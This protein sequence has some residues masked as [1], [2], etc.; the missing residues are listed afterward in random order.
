MVQ[1]IE[2]KVQLGCGTLILIALIVILFSNSGRHEQADLG[3]VL[4]KLDT[5]DRKIDQL[6]RHVQDLKAKP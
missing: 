6:E 4:Q 5:I 2:Q 3:P 1:V